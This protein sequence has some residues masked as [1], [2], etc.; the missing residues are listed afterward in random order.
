MPRFPGRAILNRLLGSLRLT[1]ALRLV[2]EGS[3][4]LTML[5]LVLVV[6]RA[7]LPLV[8]L[9]H[10]KMVVDAIAAAAQ[11]SDVAFSHALVLLGL[12]AGA[13]LQYASLFR[14]Q[15]APYREEPDVSAR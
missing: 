10:T 7:G 1:R 9:Y 12:A 13:G 2:W 6:L 4:R 3:P 14:L 8:A 5:S 11:G 15:A